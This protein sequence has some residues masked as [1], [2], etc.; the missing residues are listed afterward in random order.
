MMPATGLSASTIIPRA[1]ILSVVIFLGA[2]DDDDKPVR[3][4]PQTAATEAPLPVREWYPTPKHRQPT[5]AGQFQPVMP[6]QTYGQGAVMQQPWGVP[7][8]PVAS[9]PQ[10]PWGW[11]QQP[12]MQP[13]QQPWGWSQQPV[14]QPPQPQTQPVVPVYQY[15][16]RPWGDPTV[17][18]DNKH[19]NT[20]S[21]TWPPGSY[22]WQGGAPTSG[23]YTGWGTGP[24]GAVPYN[25]YYGNVW[26]YP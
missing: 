5:Y 18:T 11:S 17:A 14:M 25:S 8:Q 1:I 12:V 24:T 3:Q 20:Y 13:P 22:S 9:Q 6:P 2:C 10:Q 19:T 15:T 16:N 23:G 21:E 26:Q 7:P 4:Q